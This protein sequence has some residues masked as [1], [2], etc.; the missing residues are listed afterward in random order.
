MDVV[1][2]QR[3]YNAFKGKDAVAWMTSNLEVS[4]KEHALDL[5][6]QVDHFGGVF[7]IYF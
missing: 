4:S 7:D 1:L 6:N 2:N 3:D 5:G